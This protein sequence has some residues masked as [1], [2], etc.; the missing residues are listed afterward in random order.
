[1]P[2]KPQQQEEQK[3]KSLADEKKDVD[4]KDANETSGAAASGAGAGS[5]DGKKKEEKEKTKEEMSEEDRKLKESLELLVT[6]ITEPVEKGKEVSAEQRRHTRSRLQCPPACIAR[7]CPFCV[8]RSKIFV[9]D[10]LLLSLSVWI[11][12]ASPPRRRTPSA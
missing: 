10:I 7:G 9:S 12:S 11:S 2:P 4:M 3:S 1:M 8:A 6:V 5:S